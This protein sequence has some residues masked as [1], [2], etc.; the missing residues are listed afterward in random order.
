IKEKLHTNNV[1]A[2]PCKDRI[3]TV[4][5]LGGSGKSFIKDAALSG[6]DAYLTGEVNHS[7]MI[8]ARESSLS[9]FTAT[10]YVTEAV[11]LP[12]LKEI[13]NTGFHEIPCDI[14]YEYEN[15]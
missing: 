10:H 9:L 4:S 6:A 12:K 13:F 3:K 8:D 14:F 5:L 11:V 1:C 2:Y 7:G 15:F